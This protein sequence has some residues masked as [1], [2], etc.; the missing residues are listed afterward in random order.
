M[1]GLPVAL[2][3]IG[4]GPLLLFAPSAQL[5]GQHQ[6]ELSGSKYEMLADDGRWDRPKRKAHKGATHTNARRG[7]GAKAQ[8]TNSAATRQDRNVVRVGK[9]IR[10]PRSDHSTTRTVR[11]RAGTTANN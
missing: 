3:G 7:M 4:A 8:T 6:L 10:N 9:K 5:T 1:G 2:Q 11:T